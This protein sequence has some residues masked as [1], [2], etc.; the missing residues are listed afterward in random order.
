MASSLTA[1]REKYNITNNEAMS[2]IVIANT[3]IRPIRTDNVL[4]I[5]LGA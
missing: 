2:N 4:R 3:T 1:L 5:I